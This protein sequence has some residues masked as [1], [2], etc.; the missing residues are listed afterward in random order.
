LD[1]QAYQVVQALVGIR[2]TRLPM[3]TRL[4]K[5]FQQDRRHGG[6]V[7]TNNDADVDGEKNA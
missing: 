4:L 6:G 7:D 1:D 5:L 2:T 3:H